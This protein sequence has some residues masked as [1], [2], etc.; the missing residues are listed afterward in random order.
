MAWRGTAGVAI[1]SEGVDLEEGT[2]A[3]GMEG[4]LTVSSPNSPIC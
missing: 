3:S 4:C 1:G 2:E